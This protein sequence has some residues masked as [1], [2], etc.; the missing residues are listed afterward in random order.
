[1]DIYRE[2]AFKDNLTGLGNRAAYERK[3]EEIRDNGNEDMLVQLLKL[4]C[5]WTEAYQ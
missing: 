1:M 4:G 2:L 5:Q 3:M